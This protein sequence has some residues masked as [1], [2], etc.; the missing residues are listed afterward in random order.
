LSERP[1]EIKL[2]NP[3]PGFINESAHGVFTKGG[4]VLTPGYYEKK[5]SDFWKNVS[6]IS[7]ATGIKDAAVC[8]YDFAEVSDKAAFSC[9]RH[10]RL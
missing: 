8:L 6:D 9:F 10:Q 3:R 1:N 5:L 7:R 4:T 2:L